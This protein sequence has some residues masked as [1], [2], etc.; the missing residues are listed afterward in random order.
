MGVQTVINDDPSLTVRLCDGR[1]PTPV[2]LDSRL[3]TPLLSRLASSPD[4]VRPIIATTS[5]STETD[6]RKARARALEA[7]GCRIE[8]VDED[9]GGNVDLA[10]LFEKL[11][12]LG[13]ESVMVEGGSR[14]ITSMLSSGLVDFAIVTIAPRVIIAH[15]TQNIS[16]PSQ[17]T[18]SP[19]VQGTA[20]HSGML[21]AQWCKA[22][23]A[24]T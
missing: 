7:V 15:Q 18:F 12:A 9:A 3:R 22:E 24:I 20:F 13:I 6:S 8:C 11:A 10:V 23:S 16:F 19:F 21:L 14:V 5:K 4:C 17:S 2:V 1:H